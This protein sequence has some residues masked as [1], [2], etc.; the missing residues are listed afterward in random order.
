MKENI[1]KF[2]VASDEINKLKTAN[3]GLLS[4]LQHS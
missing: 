4:N 3:E 1:S 2:L